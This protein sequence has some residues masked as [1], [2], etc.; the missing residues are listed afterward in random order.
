MNPIDQALLS[1]PNLDGNE[2]I[3]LHNVLGE[4][5]EDQQ[6]NAV[7]LYKSKRKDPQMVLLTCLLGL[8]VVAGIHRFLLNQVGMGLAYLLTAGFC[9]I[10]TIID[11]VNYQKLALEYNQQAAAEAVATIKVMNRS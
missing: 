6:M 9:F 4:L 7:E 2:R 11:A 10:G 5:P 3:F 8:V 1:L